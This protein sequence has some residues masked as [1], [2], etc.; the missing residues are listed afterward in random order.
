[1]KNYL[2]TAEDEDKEISLSPEEIAK[3]QEWER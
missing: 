1:M 3:R 2:Y